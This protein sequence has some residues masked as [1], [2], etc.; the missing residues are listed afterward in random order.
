[1]LVR[2]AHKRTDWRLQRVWRC[3]RIP[4]HTWRI[5]PEPAVAPMSGGVK[6]GVCYS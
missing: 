1:M 3:A 4:A 5:G 2:E 6:N